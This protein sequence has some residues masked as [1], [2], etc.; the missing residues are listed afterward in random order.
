VNPLE[1]IDPT[2]KAPLLLVGQV[3]LGI[4][5]VATLVAQGLRIL[6]PQRSWKELIDRIRAWWWMAGL[7]FV[8]VW[9]RNAWSTVFFFTISWWAFKEYITILRTRPADHTGLLVAFLAV[10][11]QYLW[12]GM[13]WYGMFA[14]F[15]PVYVAVALGVWQVLAGETEGFVAATAQIQWGIG[16]FVYGLSHLA[17]LLRMPE[18]PFTPA[19]G[20]T[21]LVFLVFVVEISDVSQYLWG[22]TLGRHKVIPR[23][24]P[25]KTWEGLIGGMAT[26]I[27]C[28][29]GLRFL[30]PFGIGECLFVGFFVTLAGFFGGALMSAVKR[31]LGVKDFGQLIPGHGGMIDRVDGLCFA[32][33]IFFHYVRYYHYG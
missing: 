20:A 15:V 9:L 4:L 14:I 2:E 21:L 33:P 8:A 3:V 18:I 29:L 28:G 24:S 22:K 5:V 30:T 7:F 10:P 31:D 6:S 11:V 26:A 17:Y 27:L 23:V 13:E 16:T 19:G 1:L 25:N 12:V 32:A